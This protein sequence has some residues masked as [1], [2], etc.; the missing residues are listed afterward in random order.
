M[1]ACKHLRI[2][3]LNQHA[4]A[5]KLRVKTGQRNMC[6]HTRT[7]ENG[8]Q[9]Q[10]LLNVQTLACKHLL[11]WVNCMSQFADKQHAPAGKQSVLH[12]HAPPRQHRDTVAN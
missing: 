10:H 12:A 5:G 11:K 3:G 4:P 8:K 1:L 6:Q 2:I 9:N 7:V